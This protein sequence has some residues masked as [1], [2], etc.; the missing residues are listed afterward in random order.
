METRVLASFNEAE[1][2]T[3]RMAVISSLATNERWCFNEAEARTPR[4]ASLIQRVIW[5]LLM[6]Q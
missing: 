4:M 1:A 5:N 2:R 6:L 3:P